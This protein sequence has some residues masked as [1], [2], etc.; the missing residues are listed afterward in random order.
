MKIKRKETYTLPTWAEYY[1]ATG[2]TSDM[3]DDEIEQANMW[4]NKHDL[5]NAVVEVSEEDPY[6]SWS[7]DMNNIGGDVVETTFILFE[8]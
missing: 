3:T 7:N 1:F 6:F 2:E 4:L 5:R 8:D